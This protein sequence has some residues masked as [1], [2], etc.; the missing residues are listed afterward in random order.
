MHLSSG[1][2]SY[3]IKKIIFVMLRLQYHYTL[4]ISLKQT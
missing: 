3:V 4:L 1:L 2:V